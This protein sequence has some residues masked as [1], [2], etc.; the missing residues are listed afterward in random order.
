MVLYTGYGQVPMI[1]AHVTS[2]NI[3]GTCL[4]S[5][6]RADQARNPRLPADF[7]PSAAPWPG[8][9]DA[10]GAGTQTVT[11]KK[12]SG[13]VGARG[14]HFFEPAQVQIPCPMTIP[15]PSA[16]ALFLADL[17]PGVARFSGLCGC[18]RRNQNPNGLGAC[19]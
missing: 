19:H 5:P 12:T 8:D 1:W 15:N 17:G 14:C 2:R 7:D 3:C 11:S 4:S 9:T 16:Q 18:P 13:G 6:A 10:L